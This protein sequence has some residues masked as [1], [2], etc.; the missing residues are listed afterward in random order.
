MT[1][2]EYLVD[3]ATPA[4][5]EKGEAMVRRELLKIPNEATRARTERYLSDIAGG[6]GNDFRF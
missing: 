6:R 4:T 5:K 1:L 2:M 3:Y